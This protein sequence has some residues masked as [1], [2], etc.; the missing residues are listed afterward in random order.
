M[1]SKLL[2]STVW[3]DKELDEIVLI[4]YR[5]MDSDCYEGRLHYQGQ[6]SGIIYP[7]EDFYCRLVYLGL[8]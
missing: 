2:D 7:R 8:F 4:L 5:C 1:E 6:Y 3:Y